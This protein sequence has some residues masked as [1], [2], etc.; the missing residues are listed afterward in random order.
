MG[1]IYQGQLC[2]ISRLLNCYSQ[3]YWY[4]TLLVRLTPSHFTGT[5][6]GISSLSHNVA[7]TPD[8]PP[9]D[10]T[11][12]FNWSAVSTSWPELWYI[13]TWL[14]IVAALRSHYP[15]PPCGSEKSSFTLMWYMLATCWI[16]SNVDAPWEHPALSCLKYTQFTSSGIAVLSCFK[17]SSMIA[18][19]TLS[20]LQLSRMCRNVSIWGWPSEFL[21]T[22]VVCHEIPRLPN[23][24]DWLS[25]YFRGRYLVGHSKTRSIEWV[26]SDFNKSN[27]ALSQLIDLSK[28]AF[29]AS[30]FC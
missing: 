20:W 22:V 2:V 9:G 21:K 3:Y 19:V 18:A 7:L 28:W 13:Q 8:T 23:Q 10:S 24:S 1:G 16:A 30:I 27:C 4:S 12:F 11:A 5:D 29:H 15:W 14:L 25:W 6:L 26:S 17:T